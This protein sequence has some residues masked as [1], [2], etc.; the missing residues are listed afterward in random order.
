MGIFD[1]VMKATSSAAKFLLTETEEEKQERIEREK[2]ENDEKIKLEKLDTL[3]NPM[4]TYL[5][6][7]QIGEN[8]L[9]Y[10]KSIAAK[11][12]SE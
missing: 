12:G 9:A 2:A 7:G 8:E 10:L 3:R 11:I 1:S 4:R 5:K 6:K